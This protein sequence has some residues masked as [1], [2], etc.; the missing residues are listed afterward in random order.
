MKQVTGPHFFEQIQ[1][2]TFLHHYPL[3]NPKLP[4]RQTYGQ[5]VDINNPLLPHEGRNV[6]GLS[7]NTMLPHFALV[8]F[9]IPSSEFTSLPRS[10]MNVNHRS[11]ISVTSFK[12]LH[13]VYFI[14]PIPQLK[15]N[16][17]YFSSRKKMSSMFPLGIDHVLDF[18]AAGIFQF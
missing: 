9:S 4:M 17:Y 10:E 13:Q 12:E 1:C 3:E 11:V 8:F 6:P 18:I 7:C 15:K 14:S 16:A 5:I 2:S